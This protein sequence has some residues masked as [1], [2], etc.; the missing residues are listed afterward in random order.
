MTPLDA[1]DLLHRVEEALAAAGRETR[2]AL[3]ADL[4]EDSGKYANALA[5]LREEVETLTRAYTRLALLTSLRE[6]SDLTAPCYGR[7]IDRAFSAMATD[8]LEARLRP[9]P[10]PAGA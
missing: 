2:R 4:D 6:V 8:E 9:A 10:L 3:D 1:T 7:V 5:C